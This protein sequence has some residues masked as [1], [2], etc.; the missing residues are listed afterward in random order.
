M[1][2]FRDLTKEVARLSDALLALSR[3]PPVDHPPTERVDASVQTE[4]VDEPIPTGKVGEPVPVVKAAE[5]IPTGKVGEPVPVVKAPESEKSASENLDDVLAMVC[6]NGVLSL[7]QS[8]IERGATDLNRALREATRSG[9]LPLVIRLID[10]GATVIPD[11]FYYGAFHGHLQI[12]QWAYDGYTNPGI[13][14]RLWKAHSDPNFE[15]AFQYACRGGHLPV[16]EWTFRKCR[17][18]LSV[19]L[20]NACYE[21]HLSVAEW[22]VRKGAIA[23]DYAIECAM[24]S[25]QRAIIRWLSEENPGMSAVHREMVHIFYNCDA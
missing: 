8:A 11:V 15:R 24:A 3:P 25:K 7:A 9:S 16:A 5:P 13:L 2:V 19:A 6:R 23:F 20:E 1:D 21:G 4:R 18:G 14:Q 17:R 10:R 12:V 22:L